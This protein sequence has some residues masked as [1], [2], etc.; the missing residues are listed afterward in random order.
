MRWS[1]QSIVYMKT[2]AVNSILTIR[3]LIRIDCPRPKRG[4]SISKGLLALRG[5]SKGS[6]GSMRVL[7]MLPT[8]VVVV[9]VVVVVLV[10]LVVVVVVLGQ[11]QGR[12]Q[13]QG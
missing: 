6:I 4:W 1:M 5:K 8:L 10:V 11:G 9:V 12:G 2:I 3:V 13:G 7:D